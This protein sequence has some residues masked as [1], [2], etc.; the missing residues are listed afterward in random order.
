VIGDPAGLSANVIKTTTYNKVRARRG[1]LICK[2]HFASCPHL[3]TGSPSVL[4][5]APQTLI[6]D[7]GGRC[8]QSAL[9]MLS[10]SGPVMS[11][12]NLAMMLVSR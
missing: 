4:K 6:V 5:C 8:V 1:H 11:A 10:N 3:S 7:I 9:R 2:G 12:P